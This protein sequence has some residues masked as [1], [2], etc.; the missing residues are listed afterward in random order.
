MEGIHRWSG[1]FLYSGRK[2]S[3]SLSFRLT[4]NS[5]SIFM[6]GFNSP[7]LSAG[8]LGNAGLAAEVR[9]PAYSSSLRLVEKTRYRANL[10]SHSSSRIGVSIMPF[11]SRIGIAWERREDVDTGTIW[12]VPILN[13]SWNFEMLGLVAMLPSAI[14]DDSW[15]PKRPQRAESLLGIVASRLRYTFSNSDVGM[16]TIVSGGNNLRIGYLI[17]CSFNNSSGSWRLF[18]RGIYS[19]PYFHNA[20]GTRIEIPIGGRFGLKFKPR[21]G[22][23]FSLD[24][25]AGLKRDFY[26]SWRF[27][28]KGSIDFG[29]RF[30]ELSVLL[31]SDLNHAFSKKYEENVIRQIKL[32]VNWN[33]KLYSLGLNSA[34]EPYEGWYVKLEGG[35]PITGSWKL[36]AFIK[37]HETASSLLLDFRIKGNWDMGDDKLIM[38]IDVRDLVR[39]WRGGPSTRGDLILSLRWIHKLGRNG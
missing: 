27:V 22:F 31:S 14:S 16:T 18:S 29:W 10:R 25:K 1:L 35:I 12:M 13:D 19:S 39:D 28:D 7:L 21:R 8:H 37:L 15:Y 5:D 24:Y 38:L 33:R 3:G 20:K 30:S 9:N 2:I 4:E 23:Q 6:F 17:A 26:D 36:D 32:S 11:E 34:I